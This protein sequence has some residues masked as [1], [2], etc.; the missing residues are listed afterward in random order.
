MVNK[1]KTL[2][3]SP[4][5][6]LKK[7]YYLIENIFFSLFY[8]KRDFE[9]KQSEYFDKLNLSRENGV[10]IFEN[11]VKEK[12]IIKNLMSSEHQVLLSSISC[13]E[14][15]YKNILEIGTFDGE[16][17][18][19]LSK[20]FPDSK[21]T[22]LDLDDNDESFVKSYN[23]NDEQ[24]RK[25]FCLKR[26]KILSSSKNIEFKKMNSLNLCNVKDEMFDLI[27]VDGA[28][29]YPFVSMDIA[30]A[31]R[32]LSFDGLLLCD[33]ILKIKPILQDN[34]Y[35]SI[36]GY[37]SFVAL[38]NAKVLKFDLVFKRLDV[39]NNSNERFR[40]FIAIAKKL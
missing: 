17:A 39:K 9:K 18:Y 13:S 26:D 30:N 12:I 22:T 31:I 34:M 32:L 19:F 15:M 16:N 2:I 20:I 8:R 37:E 33:D 14:K 24:N 6:S 5:Y 11:L 28:H 4:I 23:R 29:G 25:E 7:I 10:N 40:K 36:A 35:H 1:I 38:Q 3:F 27:W 21:I